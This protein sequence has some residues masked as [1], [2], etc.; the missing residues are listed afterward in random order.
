MITR[1]PSA[2]S[3]PI[4]LLVAYSALQLPLAMAALPIVL[5][6]THYYGEILK[7]SLVLI[8]PILILSRLIDAIQDPLLGWW[9]DRMTHRPNG[10]LKLVAL[11]LPLLIGGFLMIF[12]PP[13]ALK[14]VS[15]NGL[16]YPY[17]LS[18]WLFA[19]LFVAHL[20]YAGVSI[21]YHS[22]GAE[23]SDDYNERTRITV[24]REVFGLT[25]MML[26]VVLPTYLTAQ[27]GEAQG[28]VWLG[29][30]F[31]PLAIVF[32]LPTLLLSPK[33]VHPPVQRKV[34]TSILASF[35]GPLKNTLFRRL[36]IVFIINGAA[37]GIAV[38]VMLFYVEHVLGGSK[39]DA[40]LILLAYFIAGALSV[41]LWMYLSRHLSKAS[42]WFIGMLLGAGGTLCAL[43]L[44]QGDIGWFIA[45]SLI[46]GVAVG[47]DY[48]L[49]P[50]ILADVVDAEEGQDS[51]GATGA[52]FGLWA[53]ATKLATAIGA[54][55]SL[56]IVAWLGFNPAK[57][58][59]D[60]SALMIVYIGLPFLVKLIAAAFLWFVRIE[61]SKPNVG[62][63]LMRR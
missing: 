31:I 6:V 39:L 62:K 7:L 17:A 5:N 58:Q 8:G 60:L 4:P 52:Y 40:G 35:L 50:S 55:A 44:G 22:L 2:A 29:L 54:S 28:Y 14:V 16:I 32:A 24:G 36:L 3:I 47:A 37:L 56:P 48:G 10:R 12:D 51:R 59:Y 20:G 57:G 34:G 25:G 27:L 61:P 15:D 9:S 11:M 49:P 63:M 18:A 43:A 41:P 21:S 53:L 19:G 38:S 13:N 45:I 23:L 33:S 30:I 46:T 1:P 26:A 42:A